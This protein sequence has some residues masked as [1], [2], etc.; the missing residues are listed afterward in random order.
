MVSIQ[1]DETLKLC[2]EGGE[3]RETTQWTIETPKG[4]FYRVEEP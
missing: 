4:K 3:T 2:G 1:E